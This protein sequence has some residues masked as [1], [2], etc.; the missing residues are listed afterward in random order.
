[1]LTR[2]RR[3]C[4]HRREGRG[5]YPALIFFTPTTTT[6]RT[7]QYRHFVHAVLLTVL[8]RTTLRAQPRYHPMLPQGGLRRRRTSHAQIAILSECRSRWLRAPATTLICDQVRPNMLSWSGSLSIAIPAPGSGMAGW[9]DSPPTA[10][11]ER[12]P[13][14]DVRW[15][16]HDDLNLPIGKQ[17][18][19]RRSFPEI[20]ADAL[21]ARNKRRVR[22]R[23]WR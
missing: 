21:N 9:A 6:L 22:R 23:Y 7:G 14:A 8:V 15:P 19:L 2:H 4:G 17:Q 20:V 10:S 13:E 11:G 12:Q 5:Q 1:M 18:S 16:E 3:H